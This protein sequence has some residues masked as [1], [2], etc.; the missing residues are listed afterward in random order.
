MKFG[1]F[2]NK[3]EII[4]REP[5]KNCF[6][7]QKGFTLLELLVVITI[8][9]II[10]TA[11]VIQHNRWNDRLVVNTQAYELALMIRQA[12]FYS[13]GVKEDKTSSNADKFNVGYGVYF[14]S[15]YNN[16]YIYFA[17]RNNNKIYNLGEEV[18]TKYL[19]R[20]VV[21]S[22]VCSLG[23]PG[24]CFYQGGGSFRKLN[25]FFFRPETKA[26]IATLNDGDN[27]VNAGGSPIRIY[28]RS[29]GNNRFA[30]QIDDNGRVS[31]YKL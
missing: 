2:L 23:S 22:D 24:W 8:A 9:T 10:T 21:I 26:Q 13:L 31:I 11:L 27:P 17:D 15:N 6:Y 3:V 18:E 12:Q 5:Y 1:K 25:I 30:V 29:P 4:L 16:R 28:L 19:N 20:G 7:S 14:D